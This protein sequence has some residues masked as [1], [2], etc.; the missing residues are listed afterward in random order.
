[1]VWGDMNSAAE[2]QAEC[3]DMPYCDTFSYVTENYK[4][5]ELERRTCYFKQAKDTK[6]KTS[7]QVGVIS[8]PRK[9]NGMLSLFNFSDTP[10]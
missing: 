5:S 3:V 7:E 1:M 6:F 8:G 4:G 10:V 9:C 2:C